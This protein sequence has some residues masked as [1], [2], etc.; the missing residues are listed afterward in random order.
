M[1]KNQRCEACGRK[2]KPS[3]ERR[4][5]E[6]N[7]YSLGCKPYKLRDEAMYFVKVLKKNSWFYKQARKFHRIFLTKKEIKK[8]GMKMR[9]A[10]IENKIQALH[11]KER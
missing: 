5:K 7:P 8:R 4:I 2:R 1:I 9:T 10:D 11:G 3:H 6:G